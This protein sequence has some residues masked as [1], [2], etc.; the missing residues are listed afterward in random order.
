ML[1]YLPTNLTIREIAGEMIV[2]TNTVKTHVRSVY[3]K[4]HV[5]GRTEAVERARGARSVAP[6]RRSAPG[7]SP[8]SPHLG[9]ARLTRYRWRVV[10][11]MTASAQTLPWASSPRPSPAGSPTGWPSRPP[12]AIRR[13]GRRGAVVAVSGGVDSG[14][15]RRSPCA[16]LGPERVLL[17]RLPERDIGGE[18]SDLGLELAQRARRADASRSRSPPRSRRSAAT[19]R[20][21]EAIRRVFP[22][23]EPT[24]G[25]SSCAR[26]PTGG[27]DRLLARRRAP[28]RHERAARACPPA[29][30]AR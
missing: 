5:H 20:R 21:D 19:A 17:L 6:E 13:L 24:G 7:F 4:L 28:R 22:D 26:A 23:Y 2:S 27:D 16:A 12:R 11:S 8:R 1:R 25:T 9:E 15:S 29:P 18:S 3:A 10:T 14:V 30:T